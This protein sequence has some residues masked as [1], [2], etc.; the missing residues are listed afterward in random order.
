MKRLK[1][2]FACLL[3]A[4]L[5]IG[6]VWADDEVVY[7]LTPVTGSDN[8]Y[9]SAEDIDITDGET[10]ITWSVMGNSKDY[11]PWRIGGKGITNAIR[12]IYS[13]NAIS[14]NITK[15]VVTHGT[16]N[17]STVSLKLYVYSSAAKAASG[18]STDLISTVDGGTLSG[19]DVITFNRPTGHDWT[20]RFYRL[21]YCCTQSGSSNKY[22]LFNEAKFYAEAAAPAYTIAAQSNDESKG[23]VSLSG[24]VIT[25]SPKVGFRY[26]S[27]AYS[28]SPAN[29]AEVSQNGNAFTV[30]PS[31]NTTV[32]INF[33][34]IP[35]YVVTWNVNGNEDTKTNVYVGEK[36]VFP[37]TPAAC[38][39]SS[40]TFIGWATAPWDGKLANLSGKNVYTS[41]DAMPAVNAA[42]T[43]YA[44]FAKSSGSASNLFE[45]AGGSSADL[46]AEGN[47][48]T[49]EGLGSDYAAGN[50]PY[51]VKLDGTGDYI[52]IDTEAAIGS[53][54]IGVKMIGGSNTSSITVQEADATDGTFTDVET[55]SISGAQND[56]VNLATTNAFAST[57]RAVKL[58]FT[59]GSNVGVGPITIAGAVSVSE[60]MTTCCTKRAITIANGIENGSVSADPASACE[61]ATVTITFSPAGGYH[62]D[63][64][65]VNSVA[66]DI[67]D[68]TFTMPDEAVTVSATFV[69]DDCT[70]LLAPTLDGVT[71]TYNSATIAWNT[72][73]DAVAYAVS[74]VKDGESEPVFSGNVNA[75]SKALADLEPETQ[76][77]YTIMAIGD[78]TVKCADGNGLL[79]GDFTTDALPTAH[80]TLVDPSGTHASS[81]DYPILTPFNLPTTA[82]ACSKTFMGWDPDEECATAP[83]YA[84]GAE[85]TFANTTG[86]TLH[87]VYADVT[88]GGTSTTDIKCTV[89]TT[90]NMTGGNDADLLV[91]ETDAADAGW[92]VTGYKGGGSNFPGLNKDGTIRLYYNASGNSYIDVTAPSTITS[93][94][95]TCK[96][97]NDNIIVKVGDNTITIEDGVYPI[98]A[99]SFE[100]VN[101]YT[102][103]NQVHI[104]NIAVNFT[105]PGTPSNY[106]TT[107]AAAPEVIVN[108]E[109]VNVSAA[110]VA[111]G[112][113]EAAYDN[114]DVDNL[115]VALFNDQACTEAFDGG[116]LTASINGDNNIAYAITEY[117]SYANDR[118]A[119]IQLTA[120]ASSTG[121]AD[122]VVVIPVTQAKKAAV[123][124][125]LE[126]LVASDAPANSNVTVSFSNVTIKSIY[127]YPNTSS[128]D[129]R[130]GV[131]FNI[132]KAG[133]DIKIY[134]NAKVSEEWVPGGTLSGTL[135]ECPWKIYSDAW[136]LAP[137]GEWAWNNLTYN[138]PP[139]VAS[140]EIRGAATNKTY[141]DG[142]EFNPAG[143][144]VIA[145]YDNSAEEDVT[146]YATWTYD[147]AKLSESDTEVEVTAEYSGK[148]DTKTIDELVVNPIPNKTIDQFIAAGGTRCYLEGVV[149]NITNT[150]YGNFDLT[151]ATGS[152]YVYGCLTPAGESAKFST[153]GVSAGDKIKVIAEEYLLY[154]SPAKDEAK[155]VVFV[156]K[157][158]PVQITIAD[159]VLEEGANWTIEVETDPAAAAANIS[160][161][162]KDDGSDAFVSLAGN[163]I[164]A[165]AVGTATIIASIPDGEG[166]LANSIEFEV[167][168]V[169][170]GSVKNVVI[171]A[172]YDGQ[173]F[174][175]K[176]E[177][178]SANNSLNALAVDYSEADGVLLD[179]EQPSAITWSRSIADGK[180][181]FLN[182]TKYITGGTGNTN[183][184]LGDAAS[185][186]TIDEA[187]HYMKG[188]RTF[189][190]YKD[191]YF[192]NYASSNHTNSDY[193]D[194]AVVL[195]DPQFKTRVNVREA[196][197]TP[198][199]M[200][201]ICPKQEIKYPTGAS[202]YTV[203]YKELVAGEPYKVFFDEI[204]EGASL[205]AGVPYLFIADEESTAI[206]GVKT[207]DL[208]TEGEKIKGLQGVINSDPGYVIIDVNADDVAARKYYIIY[209]NQIRLCGEGQFKI[210][211]ERAYLIMNDPS[212]GT[213]PVANVPGRRRVSLGVQGAQVATGLGE[214]NASEAPVKMI[215][216]G[217]LFI[218]RGEKMFN[219]NGQLVK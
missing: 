4:V 88:G 174:A 150:T 135:T 51:L 158:S 176:N 96:S 126:E 214:L 7:T 46:T 98:N 59:K 121:V 27:P 149:S 136:Q 218:L 117:T 45:W 185:E 112:V 122:A 28:V 1:L 166:Y 212:L 97:G 16:K 195:A 154:G 104:T 153:L 72:V 36:P 105:T 152:I 198:G 196:G 172:K 181:T 77:N 99:T 67:N 95:V 151:D 70:N 170:A 171:L 85:F 137:A 106:S 182:G 102:T 119:Y 5:S 199:V 35:Q 208:V 124:A 49:A 141:I 52:I 111:A 179:V 173:W 50:S 6:Q 58:L 118:K 146:T 163:V 190:F 54:E 175:L 26:A 25:G 68:N 132:Q 147:P 32:T 30:T 31:A 19:S 108:P 21:E 213:T 62:L 116:W 128:E 144:T 103:S 130:K 203:S 74:V 168:V 201:T 3:M 42:V 133:E 217:Q 90:T 39:A 155:N 47:H 216:D 23:T 202:F 188:T 194:Y 120:P 89:S 81:G 66:Q 115:S 162:I 41:A 44:V 79:E 24:S 71:K 125:S 160:Y 29:S 9:A 8:G 189:L 139:E 184:T 86:V 140:I 178:G 219:A 207:G 33:E 56:V 134:Y 109:E 83:A 205:Q 107:C 20:G 38:D 211:D 129:N 22:I 10:T 40:T 2:F 113:I 110:A 92:I 161:D 159:K 165:N 80:L 37:A 14:D 138:D 197:V 61:G 127:Y 100:I 63:S 186:W 18:G 148:T 145:I 57:S 93:I 210:N 87:A 73:T 48:V 17:I 75:L 60:Y 177:A 34:A 169:E 91:D 200:G 192:K 53:V 193:S 43:Y 65:S 94:E 209:N 183:L 82:A 101:G 142:Q 84:K 180:A 15:V 191:G 64:W 157:T 204:A 114:V 206:K 164:T 11:A 215:I 187:G 123:F 78:G 167:E 13:K 156:S 12:P 143:L 69:H 76:Y 131:V 55:L